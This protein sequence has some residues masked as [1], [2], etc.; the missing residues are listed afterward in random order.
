MRIGAGMLVAVAAATVYPSSAQY[1]PRGPYPQQEECPQGRALRQQKYFPPQLTDCQVLD[2]DTAEQRRLRQRANPASP[3]T[4]PPRPGVAQPVAAVPP[5]PRP[6]VATPP[7][8]PTAAPLPSPAAPKPAIPAPQPAA[9]P[10]PADYEGRF[11]GNWMTSAKF[12]RF[13]DGGSFVA[14]TIDNDGI[15]F[16]VR[17]LQKDLSF[18]IG[19][20]SADPKP[21][22]KGDIYLIK[23]RMDGRPVI[24]TKG[25]AISDRLIQLVTEKQWV[26]AARD[27]KETALRLEDSKGVYSTHI[28]K[29]TGAPRAFADLSRECPLE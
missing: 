2:A 16:F 21:L 6:A 1:P 22:E 18:A 20:A 5:A 7:S 13:G 26:R 10:E 14:A 9:A 8:V 23:L 11:I 29:M 28:F 12:D 25:I 24:E 27:A 15:G 19:I 3:A 17:C 4:A